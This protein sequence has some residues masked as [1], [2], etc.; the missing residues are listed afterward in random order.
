MIIALMM[1]WNPM[2]IMSNRVE[3]TGEC[4]EDVRRMIVAA[5]MDAIENS[6]HWKGQDEVG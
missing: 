3:V 4:A 6:F 5:L 1:G 2:K